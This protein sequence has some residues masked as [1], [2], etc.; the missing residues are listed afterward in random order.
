MTMDFG[1]LI[2]LNF[3]LV[4]AQTSDSSPKIVGIYISK[5]LSNKQMKTF[6]RFSDRM[7]DV[8]DQILIFK[9]VPVLIPKHVSMI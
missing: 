4:S 1:D 8:G 3:H 6:P 7:S 9:A 5:T 2:L